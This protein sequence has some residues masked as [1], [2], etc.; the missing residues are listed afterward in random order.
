MKKNLEYKTR[1]RLP[2]RIGVGTYVDS[3]SESGHIQ[4]AA[5]H[6]TNGVETSGR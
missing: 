3:V 2:L 1:V 5:E 4:K 6:F